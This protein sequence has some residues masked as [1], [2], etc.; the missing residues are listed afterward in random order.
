LAEA[1]GQAGER[2][3]LGGENLMLAEILRRIAGIA[4]RK[5]P[6]L[7]LAIPAIWPLA[8]GAEA[9]ARA[10]GREPFV[11]RDA[12]RM[13]R[14]IMFFSSDKA[15]RELGYAPRPA[16]LALADAIAWF[17]AAGMVR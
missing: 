1:R 8:I 2:Y 9:F 17:R 4:G 7:R 14:K 15:Q 11:T 13:A 3:I 12:L 5:P 10:S 6:R 16:E